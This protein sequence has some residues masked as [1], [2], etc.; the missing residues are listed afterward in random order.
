[1]VCSI[2]IKRSKMS[3]VTRATNLP[4]SSPPSAA[5]A[6]KNGNHISDKELRNTLDRFNTLI[7]VAATNFPKTNLANELSTERDEFLYL[8]RKR[9]VEQKNWSRALF[10]NEIFLDITANHFIRFVILGKLEQ[11]IILLSS[12]ILCIS[13]KVLDVASKSPNIKR[14]II[15]HLKE[16]THLIRAAERGL[17][18]SVNLSLQHGAD[19]NMKNAD[20][21]TA[22]HYAASKG[23]P[24]VVR[25]LLDNKADANI[26]DADGNTPLV[27]AVNSGCIE[28]QKLLFPLSAPSLFNNPSLS[29]ELLTLED[30]GK[31]LEEGS[32]PGTRRMLVPTLDVDDD[33]TPIIDLLQL[34]KK[35]G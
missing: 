20:G 8:V 24:E 27:C 11:L 3:T 28:S 12:D 29:F 15:S 21:K 4:N 31:E 33:I 18:D 17:N 23:R 22:L 19:P 7:R 9:A 32:K 10:I 35:K 6:P 5:V 13:Q 1:M 14:M 16:S 2:A 26:V 30:Y 34:S 25:T